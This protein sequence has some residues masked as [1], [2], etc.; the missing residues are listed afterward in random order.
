MCADREALH[1][2]A[3]CV[4]VPCDL[5]RLLC[6]NLVSGKTSGLKQTEAV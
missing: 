5:Y 1:L 2:A 3:G 6:I 4:Q